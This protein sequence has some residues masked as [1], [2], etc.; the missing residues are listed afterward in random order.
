MVLF[1]KKKINKWTPNT[2]CGSFFRTGYICVAVNH[3]NDTCF[4]NRL[5]MGSA[6]CLYYAALVKHQKGCLNVNLALCQTHCR[7][8]P[9]FSRLSKYHMIMWSKI[10]QCLTHIAFLQFLPSGQCGLCF[11]YLFQVRSLYVPTK[12]R[13]PSRGH[14]WESLVI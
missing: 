6:D 14:F 12:D 5:V 8:V 9:V 1:K 7:Q 4:G 10:N 11:G 3:E 13:S 2:G